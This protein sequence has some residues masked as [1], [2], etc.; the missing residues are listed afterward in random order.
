MIFSVGI[1]L[2]YVVVALSY[3]SFDLVYIADAIEWIA[4]LF[5]HFS[6]ASSFHN[7]NKYNTLNR[8]CVRLCKQIH[9]CTVVNM[10][11]IDAFKPCC[12]W[13]YIKSNYNNSIEFL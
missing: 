7:W 8:T 13:C 9:N 1:V 2:F 4:L 3:P 6:L 10:C 11:K 5:P 12:G